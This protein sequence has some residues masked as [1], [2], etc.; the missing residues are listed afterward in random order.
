MTSRRAPTAP[1]EFCRG[2]ANEICPATAHH[3]CIDD[4]SAQLI[5]QIPNY[6]PTIFA[7]QS[8]PEITF[9][10]DTSAAITAAIVELSASKADVKAFLDEV[11]ADLNARAAI[12]VWQNGY[13]SADGAEGILAEYRELVEK[14]EGQFAAPN[15]VEDPVTACI[16][17][18]NS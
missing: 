6:Q 10:T 18:F 12:D 2:P 14:Y 3:A 9:G 16:K 1:S 8:L 4:G 11:G 7:P 13:T 5:V 15:Q 17:A